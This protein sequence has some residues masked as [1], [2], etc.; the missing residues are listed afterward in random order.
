MAKLKMFKTAITP[1]MEMAEIMVA[2]WKD[3]RLKGATPQ[4]L[5]MSYGVTHEQAQ[6]ILQRE[7][8]KRGWA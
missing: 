6:R 8:N 4:D 2:Q 5:C 1:N 7:L 3:E